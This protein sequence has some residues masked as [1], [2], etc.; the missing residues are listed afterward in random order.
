MISYTIPAGALH[1]CLTAGNK[2]MSQR[3]EEENPRV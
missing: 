1:T 2:Q 3:K